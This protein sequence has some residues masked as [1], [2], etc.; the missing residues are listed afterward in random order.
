MD[1]KQILDLY[2]WQLGVCFRHP[3]KGEVQTAVVKTLHPPLDGDHDI[4]ACR[5]CIL[6][7]EAKRREAAERSGSGY[8]PGHAGEAQG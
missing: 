3:A 6:A 1:P 4:R 5:E 8:E 2:D 7:M